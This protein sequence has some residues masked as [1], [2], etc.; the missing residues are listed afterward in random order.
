MIP[1]I[2]QKYGNLQTFLKK[3]GYKK[4]GSGSYGM[5][6]ECSDGTVIKFFENDRAYEDFVKYCR[7]SRNI[8]VPVFYSGVKKIGNYKCV[9]ME[10]LSNTR[11][12]RRIT[13]AN[14]IQEKLD[15][16][17]VSV[18]NLKFFNDHPRLIK[19]IK[20]ISK[21]T[22]SEDIHYGN[23]LFRG[24]VPVIIDPVAH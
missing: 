5:A 15:G 10:K 20:W 1:G 8:H 14:L 16:G 9:R 17:V 2:P 4:C 23:I 6:W 12:R 13:I 21:T 3:N 11:I 18:Q 22:W 7:L 19:V 24:N